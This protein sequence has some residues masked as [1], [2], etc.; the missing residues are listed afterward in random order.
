MDPLVSVDG[1]LPIPLSVT[2]RVHAALLSGKAARHS[3]TKQRCYVYINGKTYQRECCLLGIS[4]KQNH[5]FE[6]RPH[7]TIHVKE[8]VERC[9]LDLYDRG[10]RRFIVGGATGFDLI[11]ARALAEIKIHTLKDINIVVAVPFRG[12][13]D[14]YTPAE[15]ALYHHTLRTA[16]EV[17]YLSEKFYKGA[18][19]DRNDYML[20]HSSLLVCYYNGQRGGT[21]YT[22]NRAIKL[23]HE[24]I[25][26][27]PEY[28]VMS[29]SQQSL[30]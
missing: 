25:N 28:Q 3:I 20:M 12:Q 11:A 2:C 22:V 18:F 8:R 14:G 15:K 16:D 1:C 5:P 30:F 23:G 21:M 19:L 6:L 24:I 17:K 10:F 13:E 29:S 7:D 4:R 27:C 9:I 26:L